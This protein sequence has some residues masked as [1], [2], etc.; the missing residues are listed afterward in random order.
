LNE[1]PGK[2]EQF[3]KECIAAAAEENVNVIFAALQDTAR[4]VNTGFT[5]CEKTRKGRKNTGVQL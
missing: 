2:Q 4:A 1:R 5:V 3:D